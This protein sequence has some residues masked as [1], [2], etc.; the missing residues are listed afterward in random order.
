MFRKFLVLL[1]LLVGTGILL[2]DEATGKF[3]KYEKGTEKGSGT[4]T[5]TVGDKDTDYKVNKDVKLYDGDSEVTGKDRGKLFNTLKA[6]AEVTVTFD[7]DGDKIA[8]KQ[9]KVKK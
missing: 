7:K 1:V 3:K 2:A 6:G 8:V 5:V 4:L 9:V